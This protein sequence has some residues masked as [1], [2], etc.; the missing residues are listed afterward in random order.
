MTDKPKESGFWV[1]VVPPPHV[2]PIPKLDAKDQEEYGVLSTWE[3]NYDGRMWRI[4]AWVNDIAQ[5][6]EVTK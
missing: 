4:S 3:C 1:T 2:C 5:W 6:S